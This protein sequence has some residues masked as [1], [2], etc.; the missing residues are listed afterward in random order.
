MVQQAQSEPETKQVAADDQRTEKFR[1]ALTAFVVP[2]EGSIKRLPKCFSKCPVREID[3]YF[4]FVTKVG[5]PCFKWDII[6]PAFLWKLETTISDML[7]VEK[8]SVPEGS[9]DPVISDVELYS[10]RAFIMRKANQFDGTPFTFQRLCELLTT[11][12]RHYKRTDKFLRAIEKNINVVT[13]VTEN[14]ER[15]TGV[16][17]FPQDESD[18]PR[19]IEQPFFV[20]VDEC[21]LPLETKLAAGDGSLMSLKMENGLA[22]IKKEESMGA[23]EDTKP[24]NLSAPNK[25]TLNGDN[26]ETKAEEMMDVDTSADLSTLKEQTK[27]EV[28]CYEETKMEEGEK[29]SEPDDMMEQ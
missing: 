9:K 11:P 10:Q 7:S 3:E 28:N 12:A 20:K 25:T 26:P 8:E 29:P 6:R 27:E 13:T 5:K 16:E 4:E 18:R 14:G 2:D 15:V 24:I 22:V 19:G 23:A 1:A 21:D 17:D